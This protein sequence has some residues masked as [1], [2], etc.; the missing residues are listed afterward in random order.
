MAAPGL[1][2][3]LPAP[4]QQQM[5]LDPRV[6]QALAMQQ[7]GTSTA[8]VYTPLQ[9]IARALQA[10]LGGWQQQKLN[11]EYEGKAADYNKALA[12]ALAQIN[13]GD[14]T[15]A[16][17]SLAANPYTQELGFNLGVTAAQ[18]RAE[19]A[20]AA[21]K[22]RR[23]TEREDQKWQRQVELENQKAQRER[24]QRMFDKQS[25][26][27]FQMQMKAGDR[28]FQAEQN[29]LSR[30]AATARQEASDK[31]KTK[32][33]T[34][35]ENTASFLATRVQNGLNQLNEV[36][37]KKPGAAKPEILP[38]IA[39]N[40]PYFGNDTAA[41]IVTSADRQQVEA[42]Q[43]DVLDAALTLGTGAAYT[44]EQLNGYRRSYF[45]QIGDDEKTVAA[46]RERLGTLL[47]AA[48]VKAG[49][50]APMI[51]EALAKAGLRKGPPGAPTAGAASGAKTGW[52]KAT[53]VQ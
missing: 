15:K 11:Q 38:E 37:E 24:E 1:G 41:N 13:G 20:A 48:R 52:G 30:E 40:F 31:A 17:S 32:P 23:D 25:D 3:T 35:A 42:A 47:E 28:S 27:Q 16:A 44:K 43:L 21:E 53:V 18:S 26:R 22:Y 39:R 46:K 51:D 19:Q 6:M 36:T 34:E 45:P 50:A 2:A 7:E 9:G 8:P 12:E 4:I 49:R 29:R 10:G 5:K 33:T 14:M